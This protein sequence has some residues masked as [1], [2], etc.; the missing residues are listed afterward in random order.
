MPVS[1]LDRSHVNHHEACDKG[2]EDGVTITRQK[3]GPKCSALECQAGCSRFPEIIDSWATYYSWESG[4]PELKCFPPKNILIG[5]CCT[6]SLGIRS[7]KTENSNIRRSFDKPFPLK[8]REG[9]TI[10]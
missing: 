2:M 10:C 7:V 5:L 1:L 6:A 4:A 3:S 8:S 9:E